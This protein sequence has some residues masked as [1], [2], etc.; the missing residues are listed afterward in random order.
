V[1]P[2]Y[3]SLR[4]R[5]LNQEANSPALPENRGIAA[6][7][8]PLPNKPF[9][10]QDALNL[11]VSYSLPMPTGKSN[12]LRESV[13]SFYILATGSRVPT[14]MLLHVVVP[15]LP[16]QREKGKTLQGFF[17]LDLNQGQ[18]FEGNQAYSLYLFSGE[19]MG[20]LPKLELR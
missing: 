17:S 20:S 8:A 4:T 6:F 1:K 13:L 5:G 19:V 11:Y 3:R 9:D 12:D 16:A 2:E 7:I 15:V 14:P 18:N 10:S